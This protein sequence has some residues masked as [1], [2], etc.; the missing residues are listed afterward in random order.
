MRLDK[1]PYEM[2]ADGEEKISSE[3]RLG[4]PVG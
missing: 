4:G 1:I 3:G 2:S